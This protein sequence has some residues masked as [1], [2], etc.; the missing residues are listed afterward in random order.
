[1]KAGQIV[2]AEAGRDKGRFF[3]IVETD[4][5]FA[6]ICDGKTR[7]VERPKKKKLIHL[8]AT[9]SFADPER[10]RTNKEMRRALHQFNYPHLP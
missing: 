5:K 8:K 7:P 6:L 2:Q 4:G 10:V 1:M 9:E 3:V